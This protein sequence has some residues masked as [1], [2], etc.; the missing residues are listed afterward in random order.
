MLAA[1]YR[2]HM[3]FSPRRLRV[4]SKKGNDYVIIILVILLVTFGMAILSSASST[5]AQ[6]KAGDSLYYLKHQLLFGFSLGL[7]G[8]IAGSLIYYK[9]YEQAAFFGMILGITL[10]ILTFTP[11]AFEIKGAARGVRMG[12]ITFQ[13]AEPLKLFFIIYLA[14][15]LA[16]AKGS[17]RHTNGGFIAFL[18]IVGFII[19]LLLQQPA[20]STAMLFGAIALIMYFVSGSRVKHM[21]IMIGLIVAVFGAAIYLTPYRLARVQAFF[22]PEQNAQT[23][24][25]QV[26][27]AKIAIGSGGMFG[28]G[29]GQSTSKIHYLPEPLADSI[30]AVLGE[31]FGFA[32]SVALIGLLLALVLRLFFI[33]R[34]INDQFGALLLVGFGSL[35][36]LQAAINIGAISGLI[37]LTGMTLP[38]VSYGSAAL[39]VFMTMM[40][41]AN[42]ISKHNE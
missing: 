2:K 35:I 42:N 18:A 15:L 38:F 20:T 14:A 40:G 41:I 6:V 37:P 17:E 7:A 22:Y 29:Y 19:G 13:P 8:F 11:F 36:G 24:G 39:A 34:K 1:L 16:G 28:V 9:R 26:S 30:F 10:L 4:S 27:Q 3:T 33:A 5:L 31:E 25:Y 12:D 21:L 23:S 32:G